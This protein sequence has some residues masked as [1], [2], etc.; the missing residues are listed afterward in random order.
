[1]GSTYA[2][3]QRAAH[4]DRVP[5]ATVIALIAAIKSTFAVWRDRARYRR[6]LARMGER[7]LADI[8]VNWSEIAHEAGKPFWRA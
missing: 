8:G 6:A 4:A 1:M 7:E 2:A 5:K 3:P